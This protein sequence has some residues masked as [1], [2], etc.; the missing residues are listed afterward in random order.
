MP[1]RMAIIKKSDTTDAGEDVEKQEHF[2]PL[3]GSVNQFTIVEDSMGIPQGSRNR[4][5]I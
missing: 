3:G 1:V 5:T 2:Y 4:N